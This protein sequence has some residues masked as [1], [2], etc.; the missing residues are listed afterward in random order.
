[1]TTTARSPEPADE[2]RHQPA[3][4]AAPAP[5]EERFE[6]DFTTVGGELAGY[7]VLTL[8]PSERRSWYWA[9]LVGWTRP[10]LSV[11]DNDAPLPSHGLLLRGHALWADHVCETPLE[12]WTVA[13]EV[14]AVA[15]ADADD[16]WGHQRGDLVPLAFDLEF[17][18]DPSEVSALRSTVGAE[19]VGAEIVAARCR[20]IGEI[21]V[22]SDQLE[23]DAT[24][25]RRHRWGLHDWSASRAPR[26]GRTAAGAIIH[27]APVLVDRGGARHR[28]E[29][30]LIRPARGEPSWHEWIEPESSP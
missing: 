17:E 12:H 2:T 3:S 27:R 22:G 4:V 13:N 5:W 25:A 20:V 19:T 29:R 16:A 9:A 7:A 1:M 23:I 10:F 30:A 28:I 18:N 24:G 11:V 21:H 26:P 8:R 14:Y 15:L 6:F